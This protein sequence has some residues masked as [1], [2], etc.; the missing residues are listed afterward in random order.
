MAL[1]L[2]VTGTDTGVGKTLVSCALL[3][4]L[5]ARGV[6]AVGYKPIVTGIENGRWGD[7]DALHAASDRIE[8]LERMC[9]LRFQAPMAPVP[10]AALERREIDL[11]AARAALER[12]EEKH[13]CVV[14]EG[15]GG[16]L[17]PL[18]KRTLVADFI[19]ARDFRIVLVAKAQ[20]GT[21]N[22]TLLTLNELH[23]RGLEV[24]AVIMNVTRPEDADNAQA[25][26]T[27]IERHAGRVIDATL[28][29]F[30]GDIGTRLSAATQ[31]LQVQLDINRLLKEK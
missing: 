11:D 18:D 25:S 26:R 29:Y 10:A 14:A 4:M 13:A 5:R 17:V 30:G 12:L 16:L 9:P 3:R 27:E 21:V 6:D 22:H 28:P 31:Y 2:F 7:A 23:R 15:I 8:P 24:A 19:G 20:L 1:G